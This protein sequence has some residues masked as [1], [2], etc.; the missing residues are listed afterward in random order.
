MRRRTSAKR[1]L[2]PL[3]TLGCPMKPSVQL[4]NPTSFT[5][6][7]TRSRS[8][9]SSVRQINIP[10]KSDN[11]NIPRRNENASVTSHNIA[12]CYAT[13]YTLRYVTLRY[14]SFPF[15]DFD[16]DIVCFFLSFSCRHC[17]VY[18]V[19]VSAATRLAYD[20]ICI[21]IRTYADLTF[22]F[23]RAKRGSN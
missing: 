15:F 10:H 9:K 14:S 12:S 16:L 5:M 21:V 17:A 20:I 4:T 8:P 1:S 22:L 18:S 11:A 6:R 7:F 19:S 3:T 2:A 13:R 23:I